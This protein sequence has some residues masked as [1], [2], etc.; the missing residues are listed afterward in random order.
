VILAAT[1]GARFDAMLRAQQARDMA[2]AVIMDACASAYIDA[3]CD[4]AEKE[5]AA[6]FPGQYL[7]DR[8]SPGYGDLPLSVQTELCRALDTQRTLG[9]HVTDHFLLNPSKTITAVIGLADR[10]QAARIRGCA[11]CRLQKHC[12]YQ[13]GKRC[14]L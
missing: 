14:A 1:L 13:G 6:R 5:I 2:Q 9:V 11:Y 10:P 7:T 12:P 4:E 8:F 3:A